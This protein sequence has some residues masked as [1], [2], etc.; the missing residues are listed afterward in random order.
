Q[1]HHVVMSR[2][3]WKCKQK[4]EELVE[5]LWP[6]LGDDTKDL[7]FRIGLHSGPVTAGVLRGIKG[8]F[9]LFGD[10]MNTAARMESS[11]V[12]RKI[13]ISRVEL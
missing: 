1:E 5:G 9:Q 12:K 13:H 10:A 4:M 8:R 6:S 7:G 3:A 2:F 11:G